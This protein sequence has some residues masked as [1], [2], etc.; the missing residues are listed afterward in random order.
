[1]FASTLLAA[2]LAV[3][4][5]APPEAG[6]PE[7]RETVKRGLKWLASQ[8]SND[9]TWTGNNGFF[10]VT[11]TAYAG[12]A[13]LMEGSTLQEGQYTSNLRLT[14][15]WFE[16]IA[17][18]NGLL[19]PETDQF[20]LA[21][22]MQ[23]HT[24]ALL[25]LASAYDTDDDAAR[26]KRLRPIL[27]NA[28]KYA[29]KGQTQRG[30][31]GVLASPQYDYD[32]SISTASMLQALLAAEKAG[33]LVP[34]SSLEKATKYLRDAT[35]EDGSVN[36][37]LV[38]GAFPQPYAT[39]FAAAALMATER[40]P[41]PLTRWVAY[42]KRNAAFLPKPEQLANAGVYNST[43]L[44]QYLTT[45]RIAHA[46][47]DAGH[48]TLDPKTPDAD[49]LRWSPHREGLFKYLKAAQT[50]DGSWPDVV[51]GPSH[52]TAL[53]LIMLQLDNNYLPAFSR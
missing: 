22:Y 16:K 13:L 25:F 21:R 19:V 39:T 1:M 36:Y 45:A 35:N 8:Q 6:T 5:A 3:T 53:T 51:T 4:P 23:A 48:R 50:A 47:G 18:P 33:I 49:L 46:L 52:S 30:G 26:R 40:K 12:L 29:I 15:A 42:T 9:G 20:E 28:V 37:A 11:T 44:Q 2:V 27:D 31:W 17:Q 32:D 7:V 34:R 38:N 10:T 24:S 43:A 41:S 14:V